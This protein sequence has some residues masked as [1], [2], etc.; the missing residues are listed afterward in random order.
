MRA[1]IQRVSHASVE[2]EGKVVGNIKQGL[3]ILLGVGP[4]DSES[5]ANKLSAK[6]AKLRIFG[7]KNGKMNLSI[8]DINGEAL[9]ISQFT[10][11]ADA[12]KGNRP[13]YTQAAKPDHANTLYTYFSHQLELEGLH[14]ANGKF[15]ANMNVSLL[16]QGP[17]TIIL[18]TE[19]L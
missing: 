15:G 4:E 2:V 6:I 8:K 7:D 16:N 9:V 13:S 5:E 19:T 14:V 3:M 12:R 1:V 11:Y 18:D 17:V 10:L